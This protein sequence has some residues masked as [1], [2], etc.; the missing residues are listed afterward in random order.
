M[1]EPA[2]LL[3]RHGAS[4][5]QIGRRS[6]CELVL[7]LWITLF[8]CVGCTLKQVE[9]PGCQQPPGRYVSGQRRHGD[10]IAVTQRDEGATL[11]G[12]SSSARH[13]PLSSQ[14]PP[15]DGGPEIRKWVDDIEGQRFF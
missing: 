4:I 3:H 13:L 10:L 7:C 12:S 9:P 15:I 2:L 5:R 1:L 11:N 14:S 6:V 8:C